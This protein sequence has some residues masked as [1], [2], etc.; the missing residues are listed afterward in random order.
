[1]EVVALHETEFVPLLPIAE[2]E[3]GV[4][5]VGEFVFGVEE[6]V[7]ESELPGDHEAGCLDVL[8]DGWVLDP[9]QFIGD[10]R[11]VAGKADECDTGGPPEFPGH[12][13]VPP[14]L[15]GEDVVVQDD[16]V[17]TPGGPERLIVGVAEPGVEGVGDDPAVGVGR[18]ILTEETGGLVGGAVV[19]HDQL[20]LSDGRLLEAGETLPGHLQVV[21]YGDRDG[22]AHGSLDAFRMGGDGSVLTTLAH[23]LP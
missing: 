3:I 5:E 20:P 18:L 2:G 13:I 1:M 22:V 17:L 10:P 21:Q 19:A 11:V 23:S 12:L 15:V 7:T 8:I 6:P 4:L 14:L 9:G 16:E